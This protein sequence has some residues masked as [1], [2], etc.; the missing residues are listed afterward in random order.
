MESLEIKCDVH[1]TDLHM[2]ARCLLKAAA[3]VLDILGLEAN[4]V[5]LQ[6]F[7]EILPN[8]V[9]KT[10]IENEALAYMRSIR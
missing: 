1:A 4:E 5:A 6:E 10:A 8:S 9:E 7:L 3:E 2:K